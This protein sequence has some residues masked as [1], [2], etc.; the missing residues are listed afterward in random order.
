VPRLRRLPRLKNRVRYDQKLVDK[1]TPAGAL[2][3]LD[4]ALQVMGCLEENRVTH[5]SPASRCAV[6][7]TLKIAQKKDRESRPVTVG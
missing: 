6:R 3:R 1:V 7:H 4:Y 5:S 2:E